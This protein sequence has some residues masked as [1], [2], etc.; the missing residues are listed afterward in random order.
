MD[1]IAQQT[2]MFAKIYIIMYFRYTSPGNLIQSKPDLVG[3]ARPAEAISLSV[4]QLMLAEKIRVLSLLHQK[5]LLDSRSFK[6]YFC[7]HWVGFLCDIKCL[8]D[9]FIENYVKDINQIS[10]VDANVMCF[11]SKY[12]ARS[13]CQR[14]KC[15]ACKTR[16]LDYKGREERI[17]KFI[18]NEY[19]NLFDEADRGELSAPTELCL[20]ITTLAAQAY[21][22]I[23]SDGN[24]KMKL[25]TF[26]TEQCAIFTKALHLFASSDCVFIL[27]QP[28][29]KQHENFD[30]VIQCLLL[31][32]L[33]KTN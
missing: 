4:K 29:S 16:L 7:K 22:A 11:V 5:M 12:I 13:I 33:L 10:I 26:G 3:T 30:V 24:K 31:T 20:A 17:E 18:S 14:K 19:K 25:L 32:V 21:T 27:N 6:S 28:C 23:S 1:W 8:H 2:R 15:L 9:F